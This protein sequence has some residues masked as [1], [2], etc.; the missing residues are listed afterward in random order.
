MIH[1]RRVVG[2]GVVRGGNG[3]TGDIRSVVTSRSI[4][5]MPHRMVGGRRGVV[6]GGYRSAGGVGAV[7]RHAPGSTIGRPE[8]QAFTACL[9]A[10]KGVFV[11]TSAFS[12]QAIDFASRIPQRVVLID[13][14]RLTELMV[15][16]KSPPTAPLRPAVVIG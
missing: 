4:H 16:R 3:S 12:A 13:R 2:R 5:D 9:G 6:R 11:T 7:M 1:P 14:K 8:M 15:E 10:S